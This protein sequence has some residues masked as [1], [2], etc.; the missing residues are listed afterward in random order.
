MINKKKRFF[1]IIEILV[2]LSILVLVGGFVMIK[3]KNLI[4]H[5]NC[6]K[7][8]SIFLDKLK[9]AKRL[10]TFYNSDIIL[11][12]LKNENE[13][14][15]TFNTDIFIKRKDEVFSRLKMKNFK[16]FSVNNI[17]KDNKTIVFNPNSQLLEKIKFYNLKDEEVF[18]L[19]LSKL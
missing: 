19:D 18:C 1:T 12:I 5:Y 10:S 2:C 9:A 3:S 16:S 4:E 11:N 17:K 6:Q 15:C 8:V 7:D 13:V 14:V